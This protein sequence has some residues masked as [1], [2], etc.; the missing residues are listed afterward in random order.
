M[1]WLTLLALCCI[2]LTNCSSDKNSQSEED[3]TQYVNPNIGT[4]Q[5]GP[6][7]QGNKWMGG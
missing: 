3:F 7:N 5:I 4:V 6:D 1:K 2:S